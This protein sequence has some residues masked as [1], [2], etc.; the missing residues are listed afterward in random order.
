MADPIAIN[1]QASITGAKFHACDAFVRGLMG[2]IGSGKSV[3]CVMELFGRGMQQKR[4]PDG[5]RRTRWAVIRQTYPELK[6]TTI[7]TFQEWLG[8]LSEFRW[9]SP[10][11]ATLIVPGEKVHMEFIFIA[12]ERPDDAKKLLSLEVTGIWINEAREVPKAVVDAASGRVGRFPAASA[13]GATWSGVIMDTNPPDS[14]HWWYRLAEEELPHG[15]E[16]FR[17]PG[18]LIKGAD[19]SYHPNLAAEN[20]KYLPDGHGYYLR[21]V[22][23]KTDEWIKVYVLG[24]Y[25][26]SHDGKPVYPEY[27][28]AVHCAPDPI[29]PMRGLPLY[30]GHDYGR[31]PATAICQVTPTGQFRVL[32]E[33]V[34]DP[35][36]DGM[37]LRAFMRDAVR[38]ML[39]TKY[40]GMRWISRGDPSGVARDGNDLT[41]FDIQAQEGIPTEPASTNAVES[42]LDSV[43]KY[44]LAQANGEP[45][46]LVSPS[47]T[48]I[49]KGFLGGYR[50]RRVQVAGD[51][52]YKDEP[53]KNRYSHPHDALQYAA[54]GTIEVG[55][56]SGSR[57][58]AQPVT[59]RRAAGWT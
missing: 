7:R 15:W 47:A 3:T 38:P 50:H 33:V 6:S 22:P 24:D 30:L 29:E 20:I 54:L 49:R 57:V 58:V 5:W 4:G 2:P 42:R 23:G 18:G 46:F 11:T 32:D 53:D 56:A 35:D 16:F 19:G 13:G 34:T 26:S 31:T 8:P 41:C 14:D 12:V 52:R 44:M 36:G 39:L 51:A 43:R 21:Q 27:R 1:Y 25:G 37:G 48:V 17:Q 40:A 9:D 45:G 59:P 55:Q 10:I 28:D